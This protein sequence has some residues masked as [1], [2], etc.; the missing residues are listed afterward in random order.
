[1]HFVR[2]PKPIID[3]IILHC[4]SI[5][6]L[7]LHSQ[8]LLS[9]FVEYASSLKSSLL[10]FSYFL[11][12]DFFSS[13]FSKYQLHNHSHHRWPQLTNWVLLTNGILLIWII[14]LTKTGCFPLFCGAA[15]YV[16]PCCFPS[17]CS[18]SGSSTELPREWIFN[19]N[20][21]PNK[22]L[23]VF[24]TYSS[25]MESRPRFVLSP[26]SGQ[27]IWDQAILYTQVFATM[28]F[29]SHEV[30]VCCSHSVLA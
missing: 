17:F 16:R 11:R 6:N 15:S 29:S 23:G 12:I 27:H 1:M 14:V 30:L 7:T 20:R 2:R 9:C 5:L 22:A 26:A 21:T 8:F 18:Q 24:G 3:L 13:H 4:L 28:V 10:V 25:S 19:Y